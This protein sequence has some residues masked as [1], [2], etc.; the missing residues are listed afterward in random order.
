MTSLFVQKQTEEPDKPPYL[1]KGSIK[2][3]EFEG[4]KE[5]VNLLHRKF[6]EGRYSISVRKGRKKQ[7][8]NIWK[9]SIVKAGD[10]I[11]AGVEEED[12]Q[13][14]NIETDEGVLR[15]NKRVIR[16]SS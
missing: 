14:I 1:N 16:T 15:N 9:G 2:S 7:F 3:S 11:V 6:G 8:H 5:L 4:E 13:E 12:L 10:K